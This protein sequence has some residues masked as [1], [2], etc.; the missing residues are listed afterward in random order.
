MFVGACNDTRSCLLSSTL[1]ALPYICFVFQSSTVET[2][3]I[4]LGR[5]RLGRSQLCVL[6]SVKNDTSI[7][8]LAITLREKVYHMTCSIHP[9][10]QYM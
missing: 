8:A 6:A 7:R 2:R 3:P 4:G 9:A 10:H 1:W 5:S